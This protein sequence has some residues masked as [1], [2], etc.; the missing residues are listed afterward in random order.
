VLEVI[1]KGES[2]Q[3]YATPL[4]FVHGGYHA[5]WCWDEYFLDFFAERG[6]RVLAPSLRGHGGS[7]LSQRLN[8]CSIADYVQDVCSVADELACP[9][10]VIGHSMGGFIVQKYL[11]ERH[12]PAGVLVAS[13]PPAGLKATALRTAMAHPLLTLRSA[14][15]HD[16]LAVVDSPRL[17][18]QAFFSKAT[19]DSVVRQ[20]SSR[21]QQESR[22]A[23]SLD[24]IYRDLVRPGRI[25]A[26][27]LV[28]GGRDDWMLRPRQIRAIARAYETTP[29]FFPMGHN[30]MLEPGWEKVAQHIDDWLTRHVI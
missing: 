7:S 15:G 29:V 18:R 24:V 13:A 26:P 21:V 11:E 19:P 28:L 8:D 27:M 23:L 5:A 6:Y 25:D 10:V 16:M 9:P 2:T 3:K 4:L 22:R 20:C 17:T 14:V 12:A 1:D 30:M